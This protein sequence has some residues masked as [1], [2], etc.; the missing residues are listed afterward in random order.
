MFADD[1]AIMAETEEDLQC[2]LNTLH[3]W[4]E[5]WQLHI[6]TN[7]T[8]IVH[9]RLKSQPRTSFKFKWDPSELEVVPSYKYLGVCLDEHLDY[10]NCVTALSESARKALGLLIAKSKQFGNFPFE[11]FSSLYESLVIPRMDYGA[12]VWGYRTFPKLQT[13]QNK[14][15]RHILGVGKNCPVDL[16]KGDSGWMPVWCRHEFQMLKLWF[17]LAT[18]DDTVLLKRF[19]NGH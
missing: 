6:N 17:R 4:C 3:S 16:L 7:K 18:M 2:M 5:S 8:K 19:L 14:A 10:Q 15:I 12:G 9:F 13:I 11:A 1:I